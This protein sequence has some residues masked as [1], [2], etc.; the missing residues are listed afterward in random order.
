MPIHLAPITRR[1][2]LAGSAAVGVSFAFGYKLFAAQTTDPHSWV[3][4][5]DTHIAADRKQIGRGVNMADNLKTVVQEF[6]ALPKAAR[7]GAH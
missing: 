7:R 2:F 1:R 4:L 6:L 5:A 3:L